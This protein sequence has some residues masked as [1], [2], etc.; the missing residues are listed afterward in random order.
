[1]K[2][3]RETE[4]DYRATA[5]RVVLASAGPEQLWAAT[6]SGMILRLEH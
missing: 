4:V 6:D 5:R 1:L 3:W 2:R